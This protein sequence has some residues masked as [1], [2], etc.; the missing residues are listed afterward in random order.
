MF[1]SSLSLALLTAALPFTSAIGNARVINSCAFPITLWSV[2][3]SVSVPSTLAPFG[4]SYA[5]PFTV[6]PQT[7]G[8]TIKI[9]FDADGLYTGK[10]QTSF[11]YSLDGDSVWY[12]LSDVFGNAFSGYK[13]KERS[14]D[15]TCGVIEWTNGVPPAGSQVKKCG[16]GKDVVL[17]L[18]A[19]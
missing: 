9:T 11:A 17:E 6:D 14:M 15:G 16:S 8:R 1:T 7:R 10:P 4:G 5:E 3:S 13:I 12:D 2:G 19:A 18:C